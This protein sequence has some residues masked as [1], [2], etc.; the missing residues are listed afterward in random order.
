MLYHHALDLLAPCFGLSLVP[1]INI[2]VPP[3]RPP[4]SP[5]IESNLDTLL[6]RQP[7][8]EGLGVYRPVVPPI[9]PKH[10]VARPRPDRQSHLGAVYNLTPPRVLGRPVDPDVGELRAAAVAVLAVTAVREDSKDG[11]EPVCALIAG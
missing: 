4:I 8:V 7:G 9:P 3:P 5:Y 10:R 11:R 1:D 2:S 6:D